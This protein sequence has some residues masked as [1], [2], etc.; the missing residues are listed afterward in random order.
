M[1]I[2]IL[3]VSPLRY[4]WRSR[5]RDECVRCEAKEL[6]RRAWRQHTSCRPPQDMDTIVIVVL[7]Q[8]IVE[9]LPQFFFGHEEK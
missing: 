9:L 6:P 1:I 5:L 7:A 8:W 2:S 4:G 3:L